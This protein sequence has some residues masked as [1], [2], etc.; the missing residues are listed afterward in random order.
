MRYGIFS[1]IHSNL[2]AFEAV[3]AAYKK[4]A[5]DK[6]LC[7][8]DVVGYAANPKECLAEVR[9]I[10][11]ATVAGNHDWAAVELFPDNYFNPV[12]KIAITWTRQNL[13]ES[14]SNFL[15]SLPL[16]FQNADLTLVHGTLNN[17]EEF[18]YLFSSSLAEETFK[19]LTT[20][21]CFVGHTHIPGMFVQDKNGAI[22]YL[23][24]AILDILPENR[25]IINVGSVGQP[26]DANPK[27]AY[28]VF[29]THKRQVCI[30]RVTYSMSDTV[31]KIDA[32]GLPRFLADRLLWGR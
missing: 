28:C 16:L 9:Q 20:P 21:V 17:P 23:R 31:K 3:I 29:D 24:Q 2:E 10:A 5:I 18:S 25:Y 26:R 14:E 7:V 22:R 13:S 19:L 1:D 4:E 32:A 12:A 11:A 6:Y 15:K 8:G 27:A 30:K